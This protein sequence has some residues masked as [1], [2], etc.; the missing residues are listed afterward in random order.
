M[1]IEQCNLIISEAPSGATHYVV[2]KYDFIE[3]YLKL[4]DGAVYTLNAGGTT[5]GRREDFDL[6]N[7]YY[8]HSL[9]DIRTIIELYETLSQLNEFN[10]TVDSFEWE[11]K[12]E[13][14]LERFE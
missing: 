5:W 11:S 14:L 12:K 1:S 2:L 4:E 3:A 7:H 8:I 10:Y 9:E 6:N 13:N